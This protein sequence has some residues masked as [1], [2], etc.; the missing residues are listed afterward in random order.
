MHNS[1][2]VLPL[3]LLILRIYFWVQSFDSSGFAFSCTT[4]SKFCFSCSNIGALVKISKSSWN[5][6]SIIVFV[7]FYF[8]FSTVGYSNSMPLLPPSWKNVST[9]SLKYFFSLFGLKIGFGD[10]GFI[11]FIESIFCAS[12]HVLFPPYV[13][14]ATFFISRAS[15]ILGSAFTRFSPLCIALS[16][17]ILINSR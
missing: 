16:S 3:F 4:I 7:W 1:F 9:A 5:H 8:S 6:S 14:M 13:T 2:L 15:T 11:S 12:S 17:H 10:A